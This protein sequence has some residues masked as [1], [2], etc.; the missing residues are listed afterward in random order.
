[1]QDMVYPTMIPLGLAGT[2]QLADRD[3]DVLGRRLKLMGSLGA[4][5]KRRSSV[6]DSAVRHLKENRENDK[7]KNVYTEI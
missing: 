3:E 6:Y 2:S 5:E 1:M 4:A 7:K